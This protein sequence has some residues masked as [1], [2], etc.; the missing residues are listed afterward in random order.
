MMAFLA[1]VFVMIGIG[2]GA[3]VVLEGFQSTAESKFSTKGVRLDPEEGR[4]PFAQASA[5][6]PAAVAPAAPAPEKK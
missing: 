1:A 4:A 5:E 6:K 2:F 3:S